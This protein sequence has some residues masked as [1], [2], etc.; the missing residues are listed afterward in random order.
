MS[1]SPFAS[2]D[3]ISHHGERLLKING[4]LEFG[5]DFLNKELPQ[6]VFITPNMIHDGHNSTLSTATSWTHDFLK[7]LLA[8]DAFDERTLILLTYDESED[9]NKPN[10]IASLLL[11]N[12]VPNELKG[13]RDKTFYTHYSVLSTVEYNWRLPNLGRYDVGAN[14]FQWVEDFVKESIF[15]NKKPP[16]ADTINYSESYP[17]PLNNQTDKQTAWPIPNLGL[18]GAGGEPILESIKILFKFTNGDTP[19]DG[20]GELFDVKHP[21]VYKPQPQL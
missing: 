20:S 16:N 5:A 9:Y 14:I 2:F 18:T 15:R 13:T 3:S 1:N 4:F 7:P 12:A 11:G 19:Y 21:P 6:W 17:G 8:D 10:H